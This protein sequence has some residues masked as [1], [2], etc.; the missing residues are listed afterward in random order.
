MALYV[1][2]LMRVPDARRAAGE[3]SGVSAVERGELAALVA[4]LSDAGTR[5]TAGLLRSHADTMQAAFGHGPVLPLRFGTALASREAVSAELLERDARAALERLQALDG[6]AEM[7]VVA[8]YREKPLLI[9]ILA[10]DRRLAAEAERMRRL[11]AAATHFERLRIGEAVAARVQ[12]RRIAD[13]GAMV[14]AL[15][16]HAVAVWV[17][18]PQNE[19]VALNAAFLVERSEL[20]AFDGRTEALAAERGEEL[21]VELTGPLPAYSF[22]HLEPRALAGLRRGRAPAWA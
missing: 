21:E 22:A 10:G 8:S 19:R 9:S 14:A 3:L 5:M 16:E 6:L 18:E 1:F 20:D 13:G 7:R 11:P 17:S 4:P 12:E 15:K 2:G